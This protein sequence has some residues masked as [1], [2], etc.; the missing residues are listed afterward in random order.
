MKKIIYYDFDLTQTAEKNWGPIF[1][2]YSDCLVQ[3]RTELKNILKQFGVGT[4]LA[5]QIYHTIN[6]NKILYYDEISYIA[7]RIGLEIYEILLMQLIYET[8]SACTSAVIKIGTNEFFFRTM[9]WPLTFLK[10]ITIG[11]NIKSN[12]KLIGKV[13]TWLGYVGFL[14][15]TNTIDNYTIAIN[16]RRTK[17][18][19]IIALAENLHRTISFKW[20]IGYLVRN[21]IEKNCCLYDA[22]V[23]LETSELISPCYVTLYVP[24]Y[25]TYIITRD[26][27]AKNEVNTRTENLIQT[28]CDWNK[29]E[30]NILWS[31]ER[32]KTIRSVQ[33]KIDKTDHTTLKSSD[34]LE[35]L[36][37]KPVLN[38]ET[39]YVHYQYEN[40]YETFV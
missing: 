17:E 26:C 23:I 15:A 1:D 11:L 2:D 20:P 32:I 36:L 40:E 5:E 16:Y 9:D 27:N 30:P 18:V 34:I 14:T 38:Q 39:I 31:L 8:S 28:N 22:K 4:F 12:N 37:Q 19:S 35:L 21:I 7:K 24:N 3:I 6:T 13:T 33:K 10:D 25:K 29:T